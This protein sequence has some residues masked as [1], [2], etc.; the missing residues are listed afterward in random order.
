M[1]YRREIRAI[2]SN[3]QI[4]I[5]DFVANNPFA[6]GTT[7][8]VQESN[9]MAVNKIYKIGRICWLALDVDLKI[10]NNRKCCIKYCKCTR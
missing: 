8:R 5:Y 7:Y 2:Y 3:L 10:C 4:Q 6:N 1:R 9:W